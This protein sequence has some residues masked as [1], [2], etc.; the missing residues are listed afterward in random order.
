M[1]FQILIILLFLSATSIGQ[2]SNDSLQFSLYFTQC[3]KSDTI[4]V[5]LNGVALFTKKVISSDLS[6]GVAYHVFQT[7]TALWLDSNT[8]LPKVEL[9]KN[10][11]L[12][13]AINKTT[14]RFG[15]DLKEGKYLLID[16]CHPDGSYI[17]WLELS[18]SQSKKTPEFD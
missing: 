3:F 6:D 9:K 7:E 4:T 2:K 16:K 12:E 8:K 18:I 1:R 15:V 17:G 11:L 5:K 14:Q 13:V 10:N